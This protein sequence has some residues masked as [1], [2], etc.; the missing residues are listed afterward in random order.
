MNTFKDIISEK[1]RTLSTQIEIAMQQL[2]NQCLDSWSNIDALDKLL[3]DGMS[4]LPDCSHL[5]VVT[6]NALQLS[7]TISRGTCDPTLRGQDH[8]QVPAFIG[9]LPFRG[10]SL[11]NAYLAQPDLVPCI[12]ALQAIHDDNK[13]YGFVAAEFE[14]QHLQLNEVTTKQS[15]YWRQ[16]KGDPSIRGKLFEQ[17]RV[18]STMDEYMDETMHIVNMLMENHGV[19]HA[20]L[21]FSSSRATFWHIHDPCN[22]RLHDIE[23]CINPDVCLAYPAHP[24]PNGAKV[25]ASEIRAVL[26][27]FKVLRVADENIYL[28]SASLNIMNAMVGLTFSCDGTHYMPVK[29]LLQHDL[30]FW[31]DLPAPEEPSPEKA[32]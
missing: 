5:Y 20:K 8:S 9:L 25:G 6:Q 17:Q 30:S 24:Y 15:G 16:F 26:N 11:S 22:Y 23:D 10:L 19:F 2:A 18:F 4:S 29:E 27:Y 21:H 1:K 3:L 28:R 31:F 12:T 32:G 14:L 7:S 13:L